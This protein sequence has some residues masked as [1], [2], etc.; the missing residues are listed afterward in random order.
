MNTTKAIRE[1]IVRQPAGKAFTPS[2]FAGL[3]TRASIDMALMRLT[4]AGKI[5]R[6]GRGLYVVPKASMFGIKTMPAAEQVAEAVAGAE[7]AVVSMHG[8]EAARRFG[9][10]TQMPA[11][12]VFST[13]GTSRNIQVGRLKIRLRHVS[14]RKMLLAGRP[15]GEALSALW[16]LGRNEVV[17]ATFKRISEKLPASEFT[18]LHKVKSKMPSWMAEAMNQF[19]KEVAHG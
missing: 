12:P 5:E 7:G 11:Q 9:F 10:T 14:P 19:E 17:S 2:A 13:S 15:A 8:A 16:Y 1:K 4:K 6:I 3:G 18:A